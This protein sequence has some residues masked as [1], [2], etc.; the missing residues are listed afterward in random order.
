MAVSSG[1]DVNGDEVQ[2]LNTASLDEGAVPSKD[3]PGNKKREWV[4]QLHQSESEIQKAQLE[5]HRSLMQTKAMAWEHVCDI[6]KQTEEQDANRVKWQLSV[7]DGMRRLRQKILTLS[8]QT[9]VSA[10]E[11]NGGTAGAAVSSGSSRPPAK[12]LSGAKLA[13]TVQSLEHELTVFKER[14]RQDYDELTL[15]EATTFETLKAMEER[16]TAWQEQ[17][18]KEPLVRPKSA[19]PKSTLLQKGGSR[20]AKDPKQEEQEMKNPSVKRTYTLNTANADRQVSELRDALD[21]LTAEIEHDGGATGGWLKDDHEAFMRMY[22]KCKS[23][24][25][26]TFYEQVA[27]LVH[28]THEDIAEHVVWYKEWCRKTELKKDLLAKWKDRRRQALE[29]AHHRLDE[30]RQEDLQIEAEERKRREEQKKQDDA[31]TKQRIG[32]WK[33]ERAA[34]LAQKQREVED[35]LAEQK[36]KDAKRMEEHLRRREAIVAYSQKKRE[37]Q[38]RTK[39]ASGEKKGGEVILTREQREHLRE[40]SLAY[41]RKRAQLLEECREKERQLSKGEEAPPPSKSGSTYT[42]ISSRLHDQTE[43][44]IQKLKAREKDLKEASVAGSE[45]QKYGVVPGNFAGQIGV[46]SRVQG[47]PQ[48]RQKIYG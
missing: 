22:A 8:D 38:A 9:G 33:E 5:S 7:Y 4:A 28:C 32:A 3:P 24:E 13:K 47:V 30:N 31:F 11:Q 42:H 17:T 27:Q 2:Q 15:V 48:W 25:S 29:E 1:A 39:A 18:A 23:M 20:P 14:Q 19:P 12:L 43:A 6:R 21:S 46:Q 35:K 36:L 45:G 16:F 40:R 44:Q 41:E 34:K 37:L 26:P 10:L